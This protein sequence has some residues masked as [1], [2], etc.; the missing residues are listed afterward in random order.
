M[1]VAPCVHG[2][3][4]A[5]AAPGTSPRR[6]LTSGMP[7]IHSKQVARTI[8][9][10]RR[11]THP[12]AS[13]QHE[14]PTGLNREGMSLRITGATPHETLHP[15]A[16]PWGDST[17]WNICA[18]L[19]PQAADNGSDRIA[20]SLSGQADLCAHEVLVADMMLR[21]WRNAKCN[22]SCSSCG[23]GSDHLRASARQSSCFGVLLNGD[24]QTC[25]GCKL[26]NSSTIERSDEW[27]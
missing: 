1:V 18:Q 27:T 10:Q 24:Q 19:A 14:T 6:P 15:K 4:A 7:L 21:H 11:R 26:Y 22:V 25:L 8:G 16:S 2:G 3:A 23:A 17:N 20:D 5:E 9:D 12:M 13:R